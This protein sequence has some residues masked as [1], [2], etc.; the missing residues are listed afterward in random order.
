LSEFDSCV[1]CGSK[2]VLEDYDS[3]EVVCMSCGLVLGG[4]EFAPPPERV[5]KFT[6]SSL[7]AFTSLAVGS[8]IDSAARTELNLVK[9]IDRVFERVQLPRIFVQAAINYAFRL[10]RARLSQLR[11]KTRFTCKTMSVVSV[12]H[13]I[14]ESK[15]PLSAS[16]YL[17]RLGGV[18]SVEKLMK[19]EKQASRFL[20]VANQVSDPALVM[21][22][23]RKIASM[24]EEVTDRVYV[25][26]VCSFAIKLVFVNLGVLT[27]RKANLVAA[28]ALLAA[29][30]LLDKK[31]HLKTVCRL[32][33][34]GMGSVSGLAA[35]FK[36]YAPELPKEYAASLFSNILFREIGFDV[37]S[38]NKTN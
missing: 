28:A 31:L 8:E 37:E 3:G 32:A 33:N 12:W 2:N 26:K 25:G 10:R 11:V 7:F 5:P 23:I 38:E 14:N 18:F 24:L 20:K 22:Y 21:G 4:S 6:S 35:T 16:E 1:E 27:N 34:T 29:D 13:I 19:L 30:D 9:D 17:S 36:K 15:F